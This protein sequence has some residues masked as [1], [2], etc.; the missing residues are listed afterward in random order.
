MQITT[1]LKVTVEQVAIVMQFKDWA[2]VINQSRSKGDK[3]AK[4]TRSW[5]TPSHVNS[6][7]EEQT[8]R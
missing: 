4:M 6:T 1:H 7:Q 8:V 2:E 5:C 3:R